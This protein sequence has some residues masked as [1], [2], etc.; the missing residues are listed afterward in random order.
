MRSYNSKHKWLEVEPIMW[1]FKTLMAS[2]M[3]LYSLQGGTLQALR[4][5]KIATCKRQ[6][7]QS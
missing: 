1:H 3:E 7:S 2:T 4:P 6:S 5:S